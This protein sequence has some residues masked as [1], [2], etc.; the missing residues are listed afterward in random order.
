[1]KKPSSR[2]SASIHR[3]STRAANRPELRPTPLPATVATSSLT[4]PLAATRSSLPGLAFAA[5]GAFVLALAQTVQAATIYWNGTGA[6]WTGTAGWSTA[7]GATTPNPAAVPGASDVATFDISTVSAA[8]TLTLDAAQSVLGLNIL[9]TATGG[10][11]I[12]PGTGGAAST[13]TSGS[14]GITTAAGAGLTTIAANTIVGANQT[15]KLLSDLTLSGSLTD[16]SSSLTKTGSGTLTVTGTA[17]GFTS[18][19]VVNG[20]QV[21]STPLGNSVIRIAFGSDASNPTQAEFLLSAGTM[22]TGALHQY[23]QTGVQN[24][25]GGANTSGTAAVSIADIIHSSGMTIYMQEAAGG[26]IN[27]TTPYLNTTSLTGGNVVKTGAGVLQ[28]TNP[29]SSNYFYLGTLT[30]Q[31]GTVLVNS[32]DSGLITAGTLA[33]G[34]TAS[35]KYGGPLG[36]TD[37]TQAATLGNGSTQTADNLALLTDGGSSGTP[38]LIGHNLTINSQNSAGTTT[39]GANAGSYALFTGT[40]SLNNHGVQLTAMTAGNTATFA[41]PIVDASGSNAVTIAGLGTVTLSA[42]NSYGGGTTLGSGTLIIGNASALGTGTLTIA[43]GS[44][45]SSVANLVNSQNNA[46]N[47]N[48]DFTFAGT[49]NLNLGTGAVTLG[50]SRQVTVTANTLTVGGPIAGGTFG[51][52]KAGA[53]SLTLSGS[54]SYSGGTTLSSGTLNFGNASAL[55]TGTLTIAGGSLDSSVA[56]LVN[57]QN[58]AQNWNADFTFAGTQNLN[59]GTGAVTLGASR[60]VTVAANTLTVGGPIAGGTFGLTKAGAGTLVLSGSNGYSGSTTLSTGTL[61]LSNQNALQNST[62]TMN[63][64]ALVFDGSVTGH[65]FNIGG[66]SASSSGTGYDIALQDNSGTPNPVALTAGGNNANTTYAGVLSGSGS[67]VKTGIGALTL[68]KAQTYTG[69]TVINSGTLSTSANGGLQNSSSVTVN[70]GATLAL[71][72]ADATRLINALYIYGGTVTNITTNKHSSF[73]GPV[74]M[75][76]GAIVGT[77]SGD[78]NGQFVFN[79]SSFNATSDTSGNA[80]QFNASASLLSDQTFNVTR[81]AAAPAADL[82]VSGPII[83]FGNQTNNITKSGNG[84]MV[85]SGSNTYTGST[86]VSAGTLQIGNGG[87]TGSLGSGT[88]AVTDNATLVFNRSDSIT[89]SNAI[90][91]TGTLTQAGAGTL[92]LTG[93]SSFSGATTINSGTLQIGDGATNTTSLLG[94][95]TV[96]PGTTLLVNLANSGTCAATIEN[97]G[98]VNLLNTGTITISGNI[99]GWFGAAINQTGTGTTI[100]GGINTYFGDFNINAGTVLLNN[101]YAGTDTKFNIAVPNGLAFGATALI[102]GGL[103]GTNGV[104]LTTTSGSAVSLTIG[105]SNFDSTYPGVIS[106]GSASSLTKSGSATLTLAG[107]NTYSGSTTLSTGTLNLSNQNAIQN[108]TLTMSGGAL[109]FDGSVTGHA[110][111]IGGL[112]AT[113]SGTGYDIALQ[114][115]AGTPNPVALAVGGNNASTTYAGVLSGSGSLVKT[116]T[117]TL[118]LNKTQTYTGVTVINSGALSTS[119]NAGFQNSSSVTVNSGAT[120]T[121][122]GADAT[123]LINALYIYGGTVTNITTS[124]HSSFTGAVTMVGGAIMG[125]GTGDANGQFVFNT[126]SFNATSDASGNAAQFNASASLLSDANFNVTRGAATPTADLIV[127]GAIIP[128]GAQNNRITKSGNGIMVFS[129]N[130]TYTGSTTVNAGTLQIGNGGTTGSLGSGTSAV[131]DN[132]ALVFNRSDSITVSNV[133]SGTGTLTQAGSGTLTLSGSNSYTGGTTV[134]SGTLSLASDAALGAVSGTVTLNNGGTLAT[135]GSVAFDARRKF[136]VSGGTATLDT[137]GNTDTINGALSGAGVLAKSGT[138]TLILAGSVQMAG[139][140]A[141]AGLTQ[142]ARS[143]S[144]A[145]LSVASG[146]T[147]SIAANTSGTRAVLSVSSLSIGG[148]ISALAMPPSAAPAQLNADTLGGKASTALLASAAQSALE[149]VAPEAVPEPGALGLLLA[150]ASALLGLR[151]KA[152]RSDR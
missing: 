96:N 89:V 134:N 2:R 145:A 143:G 137:Q 22:S 53:G 91:G 124:K 130:N 66:L 39:L 87:T 28:L 9:S 78:T 107:A 135:S 24:I 113:S 68:T 95:V 61:N 148:T 5:G 1:M 52:T 3:A 57:S 114:D 15:W 83:P 151:R 136:A 109:V 94:T 13:L 88:S 139:L 7:S 142:L 111:N 93:S 104:N 86:T 56:N 141:N 117:G 63:G 92:T 108:S 138:G 59:L 127:S 10:L 34:A 32:D 8:Q 128:Y 41:A 18:T 131:T 119:V 75:V 4:G 70:S 133:I 77:G 26:Q 23:L 64:G 46:Q 50:A 51:L 126:S 74:T 43:G 44:L 90:S 79:T 84:I 21:I 72:G 58:N 40:V 85:L 147:L 29:S 30:I 25:V 55:G 12:N 150:G 71:A 14:S 132:A 118:T 73:T 80:A 125:T 16:A 116:G 36:Y 45:D 47:W 65:A 100:L 105:Y 60:Q 48:A 81:G 149:P 38:R 20:G 110:F 76:G 49:Q 6:T 152:K 129:G 123:R 35:G 144:I 37:Y 101:L 106:G 97:H 42:S 121:L 31:N 67:L 99:G 112:S 82:I 103:S 69:V 19:L 122:A 120:L 17:T 54:N 115:N 98:T 146:A 62:L 11:T 33:N 27:M 140:N 102:I